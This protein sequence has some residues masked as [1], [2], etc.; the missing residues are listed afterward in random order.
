MTRGWGWGRWGEWLWRTERECDTH[1][2]R[3]RGPGGAIVA[4]RTRADGVGG[5]AGALRAPVPWRANET[6]GVLPSCRAVKV[7]A[8][9][10]REG[11]RIPLPLRAVVAGGARGVGR[12]Q[13]RGRARRARITQAACLQVL[14]ARVRV[15]PPDGALLAGVGSSRG[16]VIAHRARQRRAAH[17]GRGAGGG[18]SRAGGALELGVGTCADGAVAAGGAH[19]GGEGRC[20]LRAKVPRGAH[21]AAL[22]VDGTCVGVVRARWA[23]V[24]V[25]RRCHDGAVV[26]GGAHGA[27]RVEDGNGAQQ[28]ILPRRAL[29][30]C[31]LLAGAACGVAVRA[32]RALHIT[33]SQIEV[34]PRA[35]R[36]ADGAGGGRC[37]G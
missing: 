29:E 7:R 8:G 20:G 10:A 14:T 1:R 34:V 5:T 35:H 3:C 21:D 23:G 2:V 22:P 27:L 26:P 4:S 9:G 37:A 36:I 31:R 32:S 12:R 18:G 28:A 6:I 15:V 16:A 25:G 17:D 33:Q 13:A 24:L 19:V 11:G 30:A